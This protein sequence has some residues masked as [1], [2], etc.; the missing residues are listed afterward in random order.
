MQSSRDNEQLPVNRSLTGR[1]SSNTY[2]ALPVDRE[3]VVI[4]GTVLFV[5][6]EST[7]HA[8]HMFYTS[9]HRTKS[10]RV[11]HDGLMHIFSVEIAKINTVVFKASHSFLN[12]QGYIHFIFIE[13][14]TSRHSRTY[15][16]RSYTSRHLGPH[17]FEQGDGSTV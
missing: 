16:R 5:Q 14:G 12:V 17:R 3:R 15:W 6:K 10:S 9:A 2:I 7:R 11:L 1:L 4:Y 8:S 13:T